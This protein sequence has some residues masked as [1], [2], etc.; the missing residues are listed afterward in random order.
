MEY[1]VSHGMLTDYTSTK[2]MRKL[3]EGLQFLHECCFIHT[4]LTVRNAD[5]AVLDV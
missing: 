5:S 3:V 1:V 2:L 4:N